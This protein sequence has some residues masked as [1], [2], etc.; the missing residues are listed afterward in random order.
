[1]NI[2]VKELTHMCKGCQTM[3]KMTGCAYMLCLHLCASMCDSVLTR[4]FSL[5]DMKYTA[6]LFKMDSRERL[7]ANF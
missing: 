2:A 1:M 5:V 4:Y 6:V 3:R 7:G